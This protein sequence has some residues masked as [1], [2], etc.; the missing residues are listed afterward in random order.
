MFLFKPSVYIKLERKRYLHKF[1]DHIPQYIKFKGFS[2]VHH[3]YSK[4]YMFKVYEVVPRS[5]FRLN[6]ISRQTAKNYFHSSPTTSK[7]PIYLFSRKMA[8]IR[9]HI[10]SW[11]CKCNN[12]VGLPN[13]V[14]ARNDVPWLLVRQQVS[15]NHVNKYERFME[16]QM[17]DQ[18][19]RS[20]L[21]WDWVL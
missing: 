16:V 5:Q 4:I 11:S 17:I 10:C 12:L 18:K 15:Q 1:I 8:F 21:S 14:R 7:D 19:I 2:S 13:S 6:Q 3:L 9:N 20:S